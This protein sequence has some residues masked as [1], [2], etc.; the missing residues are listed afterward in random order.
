[1][2]SLTPVLTACSPRPIRVSGEQF[3]ADLLQGIR[4][5]LSTPEGATD[6]AQ[7]DKIRLDVLNGSP[8]EY[9]DYA[10]SAK[11]ML[12]RAGINDVDV[13]IHLEPSA[14]QRVLERLNN[15]DEANMGVAFQ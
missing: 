1:M 7:N 4:G 15:R 13:S 2:P 8:S 9:K 12:T 6:R 14:A 5:Q 3:A 11:R 10:T